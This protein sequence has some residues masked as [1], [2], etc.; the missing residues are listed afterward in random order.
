MLSTI[1]CKKVPYLEK[2]VYTYTQ[3]ESTLY[4]FNL[5]GTFLRQQA[6]PKPT[7]Q[8][9][10]EVGANECIQLSSHRCE[11]GSDQ[12]EGVQSDEREEEEGVQSDDREE[13]EGVQSNDRE[14][15]EG[16]QSNDREEEEGVQSDD[17]EEEDGVQSNDGEEEDGVQSDERE[18]EEGVSK[19]SDI[20]ESQDRLQKLDT[21][22][23]PILEH[24]GID[25]S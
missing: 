17:R 1:Q 16:V 15:E 23:D 10:E 14:E 4:P 3:V 18:E 12:E 21:K 5:T 25:S 19:G 2:Y 8:K 22:S 24:S 11:E 7:S 13:E 20:G 6:R 9:R